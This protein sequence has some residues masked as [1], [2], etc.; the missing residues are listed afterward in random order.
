M[1]VLQRIR[2]NSSN[3]TADHR[4]EHAAASLVSDESTRSTTEQRRAEALLA[5]LSWALKARAWRSTS[6]ALVLITVLGLRGMAAGVGR[7]LLWVGSW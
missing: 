6:R 4:S 3:N 5:V 2:T 7:T 1:L